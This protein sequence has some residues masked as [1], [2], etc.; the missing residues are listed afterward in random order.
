MS[1]RLREHEST[2]EAYLYQQL[3]TFKLKCLKFSTLT[4]TGWPDRVIILPNKQVIWIEAK[5]SYGR[6]RPRQRVVQKLLQTLGHLYI[7]IRS[8]EDVDNVMSIIKG[9][10]HDQR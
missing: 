4:E 6:L 3:K 8:N 7:V 9:V 2:Y 5:T 10:I 1:T